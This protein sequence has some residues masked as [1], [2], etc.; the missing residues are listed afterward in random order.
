MM[1]DDPIGHWMK[2]MREDEERRTAR[3]V[4]RITLGSAVLGLLFLGAAVF[5][6]GCEFVYLPEC[7]TD[8]QAGGGDDS[9]GKAT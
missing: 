5:L 3:N 6:S 2:M 1:I 4:L 8:C 7:D 9:Y